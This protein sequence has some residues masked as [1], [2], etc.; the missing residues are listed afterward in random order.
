MLDEYTVVIYSRPQENK[1]MPRLIPENQYTS[2]GWHSPQYLEDARWRMEL[3]IIPFEYCSLERAAKFFGC[4]MEDFFHWYETK[5]I[6]LSLKLLEHRATV[7]SIDNKTIEYKT[8]YWGDDH[9]E[10]DV[11]ASANNEFSYIDNISAFVGNR[12]SYDHLC[13]VY[14]VNGYA[15]DF[16]RPCDA[17]IQSLRRG[18]RIMDSFS[19]SP[20]DFEGDFR[21]MIEVQEGTQTSDPESPVFYFYPEFT[22]GDLVLYKTDLDI[23][24]H[25]MCGVEYSPEKSNELNSDLLTVADISTEE[26]QSE[27][28]EWTEFSSKETSLKFIAGMVLALH[29]SSPKFRNGT[30]INRTSIAKEAILRITEQGI[31]FDI[32]ERQLTNL[33]NKAL[34]DYAPK[35]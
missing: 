14:R 27:I 31:E 34:T 26:I 2:T 24:N 20:Y 13:Q 6:S 1:A 18:G 28:L 3:K 12:L 15:H 25:L 19:A 32:T 7:L 17:F 30:K 29:K 9:I 5:K 22:I 11:M 23:I 21:I 16:W 10:Y 8:E 4:E 33:M 35:I